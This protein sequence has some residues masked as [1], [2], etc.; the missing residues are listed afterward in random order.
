VRQHADE[1]LTRDATRHLLDELKSNAPAVVDELIPGLMKAAEVQQVLQLLLREGVPIRQ[2]GLILEALGD[3]APRS[4]D[5]VALTEVARQK[6]ARTLCTKFRDSDKRMYVVTLDPVL[7]EQVHG[8]FEHSDDGIEIHLA[9]PAID[10]ICQMIEDELERLTFAHRPP[11]VLVS[12][13][14]RAAL[15]QMTAGR[16]PQLI[17]LSYSEMTNDTHVESVATIGN[18]AAAA[19]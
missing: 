14:I 1:L 18:T 11:I 15:R 7:E 17:V 4:K 2:L 6:L 19:A 13:Q 8:G 9:P 10:A 5:P 12:P 16:L 3:A